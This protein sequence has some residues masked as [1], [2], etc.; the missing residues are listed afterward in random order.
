M[1]TSLSRPILFILAP[2]VAALL[3]LQSA[4]PANAGTH[5]G[6]DPS[7]F[8]AVGAQVF[9]AATTAAHGRELWVT[10][11]TAA[12][13]HE[14]ADINSAAGVGS[15]PNQLTALG[16]RVYFFADDGTGTA[17]WKSDGTAAGT[18]RLGGG[19][20]GSL[21]IVSGRLFFITCEGCT[22]STLWTSNGTARGT[23]PIATV[24]DSWGPWAVLGGFYY[25][26]GSPDDE[27][28]SLWKSDGTSAGTSAVAQIAAFIDEDGNTV[29]YAGPYTMVVSGNRLYFLMESP[30]YAGGGDLWQSDGTA[31]GTRQLR[32]FDPS[33][34]PDYVNSNM[35]GLAGTLYLGA[36]DEISMSLWKS[37]GTDTGTR[38]VKRL[39]PDEMTAVGS[40]LFLFAWDGSG[41]EALW[42]TKGTRSTTVKVYPIGLP[43]CT[44]MTREEPYCDLDR[45]PAAVG[46]RLFFPAYSKG[47][48]TE[49]WVSDG[50][51]AGT[52]QVKNILYGGASS[53]PSDLAG[54]G[55]LL[56][57]SARDANHG[58]ELWVSDGTARG[59]HMVI[60]IN[61]G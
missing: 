53:N 9:F 36:Q 19:D 57:F 25:F 24:G 7:G 26:F 51:T 49:L 30:Y 12:G 50:T 47:N 52:H 16:D 56:Y 44:S 54:V 13:T 41:G 28:W 33:R 60:D 38:I 18:K 15:D 29:D 32:D 3:V 21:A 5:P 58:R 48:G 37:D 4:V 42:R 27:T 43:E 20:G 6:S 55:S 23:R 10:D 35:A 2:V 22:Q 14:V 39:A 46:S 1:R 8:T 59:T 61:P 45:T 11:G 40:R 34:T 17:L 31:A